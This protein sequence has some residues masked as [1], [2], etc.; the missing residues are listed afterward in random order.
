MR[1]TYWDLPDLIEVECCARHG[2]WSANA[3]AYESPIELEHQ[4]DPIIDWTSNLIGDLVLNV[5]IQNQLDLIDLRFRT[6]DLAR[7]VECEVRIKKTDTPIQTSVIWQAAFS[8]RT[9]PSLIERF[10]RS[11]RLMLNSPGHE[12]V[13]EGV[14]S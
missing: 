1:V 6:V 7:H 12:A 14:I 2:G 3:L 13:L 8:F 4:I 10:G 5:G 11:L 9:E